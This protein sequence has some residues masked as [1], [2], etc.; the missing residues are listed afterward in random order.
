MAF[1]NIKYDTCRIE[2]DMQISTEPGRYQIAVPGPGNN[3]SFQEDPFLRLQKYGANLRTNTINLESELMG[4]TR[5]LNRDS[6]HL[7]TYNKNNIRNSK[8]NYPSSSPFTEQSRATH[9]AWMYIDL[10]Q[11][12]W[13]IL[14]LNPQENTCIPFQN[15]LST[16]ILEKDHYVPDYPNINDSNKLSVS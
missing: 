1:T 10:E 15:N 12:N 8:I 6:V 14:P 9:P 5:S 2:K 16:R 13:G 11:T 7:N 3:V 4:L